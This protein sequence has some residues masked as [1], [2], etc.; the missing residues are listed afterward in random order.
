MTKS[1]LRCGA[2]CLFLFWKTAPLGAQQLPS[3][4]QFALDCIEE[5]GSTGYQDMYSHGQCGS[6]WWVKCYFQDYCCS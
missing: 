1:M 4:S 3:C 2:A 6:A 5:H